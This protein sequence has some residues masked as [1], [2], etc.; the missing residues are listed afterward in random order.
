VN[1]LFYLINE[2]GKHLG[3]INC[4]EKAFASGQHFTGFV[5]DFR[6]VDVAPSADVA[7][8]A[9]HGQS[10]SQRNWLNVFHVHLLGERQHVAEFVYFAHGFIKDGGNDSAMSM[11]RRPLVAA[12]QLELA[13]CAPRVS[14][15]EK[16]EPHA[17]R[18]VASAAEAVIEPMFLMFSAVSVEW[19]VVGHGSAKF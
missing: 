14:I 2:L 5:G 7:L 18:I 11:A 16:L 4:D 1:I 19:F 8:V 15:D 10:L 9:Y 17:V 12:R 6:D 3:W 13:E